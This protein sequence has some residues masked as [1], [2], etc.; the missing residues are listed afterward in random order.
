[1][2]LSQR[3]D[4]TDCTDFL[5]SK[6]TIKAMVF[7]EKIVIVSNINALLVCHSR[8]KR[9]KLLSSYKVGH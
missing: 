7:A 9:I 5:K 4:T 6:R 8:E 2:V 1:M 3:K